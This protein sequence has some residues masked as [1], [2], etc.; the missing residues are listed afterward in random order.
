MSHRIVGG[1]VTVANRAQQDFI[2]LSDNKALDKD[3]YMRLED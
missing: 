1:K 3:I 2:Y